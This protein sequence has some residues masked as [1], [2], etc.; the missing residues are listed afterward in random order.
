M[1]LNIDQNDFV[2][3]KTVD[4]YRVTRIDNSEDRHTHLKS[5]SACN[6]VIQNVINRKIPK[7]VGSYYLTS[8][9][10][11]SD[12]AE[13]IGKIEELIETRKLKGKKQNYYNPHKK[14]R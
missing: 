1:V 14:S 4:G 13:Y 6:T 3:Y 5:K 7:N 8:L 10:R 12:D 9:I 11:L 2:I